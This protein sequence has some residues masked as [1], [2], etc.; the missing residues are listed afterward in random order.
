M[1]PPALPGPKR[2][3]CAL[4]YVGS[5]FTA[6]VLA[7]DY[8]TASGNS[9]NLSDIQ[10]RNLM[11]LKPAGFLPDLDGARLY[12]GKKTILIDPASDPVMANNNFRL[13]LRRNT[14]VMLLEEEV[15]GTHFNVGFRGMTPNNAV[16]T[17]VYQ[18]GFPLNV[19][20]FGNRLVVSVP[21]LN[22]ITQMQLVNGGSSVL[23]GPQPGGSVNFIS[24]PVAGDRAYRVRNTAAGGYYG[25]FSDLVE[26]S[27]TIDD[28]SYGAF[29]RYSRGDG[30]GGDPA[31]QP[32]FDTT[33]GGAR[34]IKR[35]GEADTL[36]L[37]YQSY[38]FKSDQL[39]SV[40]LGSGAGALGVNAL[41]NY[42]FQETSQ[43]RIDLLYQHDFTPATR[44]ESRS[45]FHYTRGFS[46]FSAQN[47]P[48]LGPTTEKFYNWGTDTRLVHEYDLANLTGNILT[49]GFTVQGTISPITSRL[50]PGKSGTLIDLDRHDL[51]WALYAENK[52][53]I[54]D[55]WSVTPG[56]R[57][58]YAEV[59][60]HGLRNQDKMNDP[61][62]PKQVD[63]R[64]DDYAPLF[65]LGTEVDLLEPRG[66]NL[67]PLVFYANVANAYR[68]P[69]YNETVM[70]DPRV[71][72]GRL[73][74][75][76]LYQ[77]EAGL[78][79]TPT[80][81][82]LYDLSVFGMR[83]EKQFAFSGDVNA[84]T[85]IIENSGRTS[86]RGVEWFQE[87]NLFGLIDALNQT[88]PSAQPRTGPR[89]PATE[90][91]WARHGRLS[92]FTA[93]SYLDTE[94]ESSPVASAVGRRVPYAPEWVFKAGLAYNYFER[95]KAALSF[96]YV[97]D[98]FGN[99]NND[100]SL[101]TDNSSALIPSYSVVDL[102]LEYSCWKDRLTFFLNLNNLLGEG[103]FAGLQG[104]SG[105]GG[106]ITAPGRNVYGGLRLSF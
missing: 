44:A 1:K 68:P 65:S 39:S 77:V 79:G 93:L 7:G 46:D 9:E 57:V 30:F 52:F 17:Q 61:N 56:I 97:S 43:H 6:S 100:N 47:D 92:L 50:R 5:V 88:P 74:N 29:F 64:F 40:I 87:V 3:W 105:A 4:I 41:L 42:Y 37:S 55:R 85:A 51:N 35:L 25:H 95:L 27:G 15:Q 82:Y 12:S 31:V 101:V 76:P 96:R 11:E 90:I 13:A 33:S 103:Y 36:S 78:R 21:D 54:L 62:D 14:G 16:F 91:G 58:E 72:I 28:Y 102:S 99:I 80:P 22:Q 19:D 53:Q 106:Q 83:Y 8:P 34:L 59:A 66:I 48:S 69:T 71:A 2:R 63:R 104:Q 32:A 86:H 38:E 18:D 60:G 67:R 73:D 75:A 81:W 45:W 89:S 26:A 94:I 24:Y 10:L 98:N 20:V 70:Q 84:G 23:F 49:A